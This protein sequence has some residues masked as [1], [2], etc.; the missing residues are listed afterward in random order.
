M[1]KKRASMDLQYRVTLSVHLSVESSL[2][3]PW[4]STTLV[5]RDIPHSYLRTHRTIKDGTSTR[6]QTN[7]LTVYCIALQSIFG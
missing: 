1:I 2:W 7:Q 5:S 4:K 6:I 3:A